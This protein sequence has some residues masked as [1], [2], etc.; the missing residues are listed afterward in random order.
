M[1]RQSARSCA[2]AAGIGT[3]HASLRR[4][5]LAAQQQEARADLARA[6]ER[7]GVHADSAVFNMGTR[8]LTPFLMRAG[9][10][11]ANPAGP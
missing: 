7:K 9:G 1:T 4:A 11:W 5:F 3:N 10:A 6:A 2:L 8:S